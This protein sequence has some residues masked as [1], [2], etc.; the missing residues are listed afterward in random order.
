MIMGKTRDQ[1][2]SLLFE[3]SELQTLSA[4]R[5]A[6]RRSNEDEHPRLSK[7]RLHVLWLGLPVGIGIVGMLLL[8]LSAI[9][10]HPA[11]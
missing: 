2:D 11:G 6:G 9:G 1:I 3:G 4:L 5:R 10:V 7:I 8:V